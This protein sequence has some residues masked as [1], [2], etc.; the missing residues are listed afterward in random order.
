MSKAVRGKI[1]TGNA[2]SSK[3]NKSK[4]WLHNLFKKAQPDHR[5]QSFYVQC[6]TAQWFESHFIDSDSRET[7]L[8]QRRA[9]RECTERIQ[10]ADIRR[11]VQAWGQDVM[12]ELF[13]AC[14]A[15]NNSHDNSTICF[16]PLPESVGI[17]RWGS[18]PNCSCYK[19]VQNEKLICG[20]SKVGPSSLVL[21]AILKTGWLTIWCSG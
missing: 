3:Q 20:I 8:E 2:V 10:P 13:P 14:K 17:P 5:T 16:L 21:S 18:L 7:I 12:I 15:F 6:V 1:K 19:N 9:C 11:N 4:G